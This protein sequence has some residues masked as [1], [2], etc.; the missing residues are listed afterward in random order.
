MSIET[1]KTEHGVWEI[2][3]NNDGMWQAIPQSLQ[4]PF[5]EADT[6]GGV[7]YKV[8]TF[9]PNVFP[10]D[11]ELIKDKEG[12][13]MIQEKKPFPSVGVKW[14]EY[15]REEIQEFLDWCVEHGATAYEA[16]VSYGLAEKP[17]TA[18]Y[19]DISFRLF[20]VDTFQRTYIQDVEAAYDVVV[21]TIE[22]A[23]ELIRKELSL[24][25]PQKSFQAVGAKIFV[26]DE[27]LLCM[28]QQ[29]IKSTSGNIEE[30]YACLKDVLDAAYKQ[31]SEGKGAERHACSRAFDEQPMQLISELLNSDAGMAFQAIKK[32]QEARRMDSFDRYERELLGA[33]NYIAGM[34]IHKKKLEGK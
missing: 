3:H 32:I 24:E 29:T 27:E 13:S 22:E 18:H 1:I 19:P 11:V 7:S 10:K 4:L 26:N 12:H 16:V 25:E 34:I 33:I 30:D 14:G 21:N 5:L 20:G 2:L 31:A 15:S 6:I 28:Q 8:H 9:V 17:Y 23:K